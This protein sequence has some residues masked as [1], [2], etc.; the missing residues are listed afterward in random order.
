[1]VRKLFPVKFKKINPEEIPPE[2]LVGH[3]DED[4][5]ADDGGEEQ[6]VI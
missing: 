5:P 6:K 1:M 2:M 4:K 3:D